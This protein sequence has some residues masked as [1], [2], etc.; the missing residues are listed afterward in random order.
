MKVH[1][2][3]RIYTTNSPHYSRAIPAEVAFVPSCEYRPLAAARAA[4]R[5]T[6]EGKAKRKGAYTASSQKKTKNFDSQT[7][8]KGPVVC[9]AAGGPGAKKYM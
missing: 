4:A 8:P 7:S 9:P 2:A 6:T 3:T 1:R 5:H